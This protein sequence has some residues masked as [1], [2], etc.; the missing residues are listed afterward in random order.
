MIRFIQRSIS[1]K[2]LL[3]VLA[4]TFTALLVSALAMLAYDVR[5]FRTTWVSDLTTQADI[6]ARTSVPAIQFDDPKAAHENLALLRNRPAILEA[7]IYLAN[8]KPFASYVGSGGAALAIPR[9]AQAPGYHVGA[10]RITMSQTITEKGEVLGTVFLE[11]SYPL[12]DRLKSYLLIMGGVMLASLVVAA[13]TSLWLQSAF[14]APILAVTRVAREVIQRRDFSL[15]ATKATDDEIG[16]LVDAFNAMLAEVGRRARALEESNRIL[17][18]EMAQREEA[19]EALLAADRRKDEFLATLAHE[20]RNPLAPLST[21]IALLKRTASASAHATPALDIMERQLRHMVRLI[22]D[23]LDVSRITTGKLTVRKERVLLQ[24]VI[25]NA[26][27]ATLPLLEERGHSLHVSLPDTPVHMDADPARIAQVFA[28]LLNNAAKYTPR[29]G[30]VEL[31]VTCESEALV[32]AVSD[33][34]IGIAPDMLPKIFAM[35]VQA[36]ESPDRVST[37]LGVGLCLARRLVELHGGQIDA[38]SGG[39]SL[40]STFTV[41]LPCATQGVASA[42]AAVPGREEAPRGERIML[43][44]DNEDFV[45]SL[46]LLLEAHGHTVHVAHNGSDALALAQRERPSFCFLDIGLPRMNGYELAR[47]LRAD[48]AT[49]SAVLVA[50]TGWGQEQDRLRAREAGFDHHFVKP[51]EVDVLQAVLTG[52]GTPAVSAGSNGHGPGG[53]TARS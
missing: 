22:D 7:A 3:M 30:R 44:D 39:R 17:G 53:E 32:A 20:L 9:Q 48:D 38:T 11:A 42:A 27:E 21:S 47:R 1:R 46:A 6:L 29:G 18:R 31:T 2:L 52:R 4:T 50:I 5:N 40:G 14:T 12:A 8:G 26:V 45:A 16:V 15:R 10:D 25:Q 33:N 24:S 37:G 35:F 28:N 23:L 43:A 51:V 36:D 49:R 34:G 19:Q 13:L 41:R